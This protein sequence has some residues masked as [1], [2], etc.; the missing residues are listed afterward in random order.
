MAVSE[1]LMGRIL[2][3]ELFDSSHQ[4]KGLPSDHVPARA[5]ATGETV[6][7]PEGDEN[8]PG[9]RVLHRFGA[10]HLCLCGPNAS[11]SGSGG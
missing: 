1:L 3:R 10:D 2:A 7:P 6:L 9:P 4:Y 5:G 8:N 11:S